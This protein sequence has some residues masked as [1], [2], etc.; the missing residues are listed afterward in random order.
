MDSSEKLSS[1]YNQIKWLEVNA[2]FPITDTESVNSPYLC[3]T[4][5]W[6][7]QFHI[8]FLIICR[9]P[10]DNKPNGNME[11]WRGRMWHRYKYNCGF[12]FT[13][14]PQERHSRWKKTSERP[15]LTHLLQGGWVC[16]RSDEK[17]C[18]LFDGILWEIYHCLF[19]L[20]TI[21]VALI[22]RNVRL[23]FFTFFSR[24]FFSCRKF[25]KKRR[26]HQPTPLRWAAQ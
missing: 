18:I 8:C 26:K 2:I 7:V 19:H 9:V 23:A 25:R 17:I 10:F 15:R 3:L 14:Q 21:F 4:I 13:V 1:A 24:S 22:V 20:H 11:S 16:G 5:N 6:I 12:E